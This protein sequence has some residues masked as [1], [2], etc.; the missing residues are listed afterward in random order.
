MFSTV[1]SFVE[2]LQSPELCKVFKSDKDF[3]LN[4]SSASIFWAQ[5][6]L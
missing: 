2:H 1:L 3:K 4:F 6:N 5:C